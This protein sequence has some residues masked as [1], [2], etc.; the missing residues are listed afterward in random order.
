MS[1]NQK[2]LAEG[3]ISY[4]QYQSMAA[5]KFLCYNN[6]E[7]LDTDESYTKYGIV[8]WYPVIGFDTKDGREITSCKGFARYMME[9]LGVSDFDDSE[10]DDDPGDTGVSFVYREMGWTWMRED[11]C[12]I[13]DNMNQMIYYTFGACFGGEALPLA[14]YCEGYHEMWE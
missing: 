1:A 10:V 13:R 4:T 8:K 11:V 2:A 5:H 14:Q 6:W 7:D 12:S 9:S 3:R